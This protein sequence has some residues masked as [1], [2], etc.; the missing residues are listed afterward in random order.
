VRSTV[1]FRAA[2]AKVRGVWKMTV[3]IAGD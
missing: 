1:D 3:F 2:I